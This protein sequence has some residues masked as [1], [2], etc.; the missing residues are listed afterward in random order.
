MSATERG[1]HAASRSASRRGSNFS[2]ATKRPASKR[3]ECRAPQTPTAFRPPAQGWTAPRG[4]TLGH[5]S[6][7]F[8]N[9]EGVVS[10]PFR[11]ST[12]SG[13][14]SGGTRSQG[15]SPARNP[16]LTGRIPLGF[17]ATCLSSLDALIAA[18]TQKHAALQRH[19]RGLMQQLF[20]SPEDR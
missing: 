20:P 5:R 15:S 3:H 4:T 6:G 17:I 12:P 11:A 1:V 16:G 8:S 2:I 10:F 14:L 18:E 7:M 13:L 19:K 9:P